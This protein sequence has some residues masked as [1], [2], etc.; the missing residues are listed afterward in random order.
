MLLHLPVNGINDDC[1][2]YCVFIVDDDPFF[3]AAQRQF[4]NNSISGV[5]VIQMTGVDIER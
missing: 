3:C 5:G 1:G 2:R 4:R